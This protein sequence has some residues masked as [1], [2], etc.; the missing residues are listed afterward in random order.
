V[1]ELNHRYPVAPKK[2][3]VCAVVKEGRV[4]VDPDTIRDPVI[5]VTCN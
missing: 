4:I 2:E 1:V 3:L 5:L